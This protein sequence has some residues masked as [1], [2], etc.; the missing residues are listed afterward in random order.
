MPIRKPAR[1]KGPKF[2]GRTPK[3]RRRQKFMR[4]GEAKKRGE[5]ESGAT[6]QPE[7]TLH[8][9]LFEPPTSFPEH[10]AAFL[11]GWKTFVEAGHRKIPA[12]DLRHIDFK[13]LDET[14][15]KYREL[16][17][18]GNGLAWLQER[19]QL[20]RERMAELAKIPFAKRTPKDRA[21]INHLSLRI[22]EMKVFLKSIGKLYE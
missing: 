1:G 19:L 21:A 22:A 20:Q 7:P 13:K 4:G 3:S 9:H 10:N 12:E 17:S 14:A 18:K 5:A 2:P 16:F 15:E 8:P 11:N 6:Q